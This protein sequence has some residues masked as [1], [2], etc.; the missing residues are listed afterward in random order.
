VMR[1]SFVD[2]ALER[3]PCPVIF[4]A[5]YRGHRSCDRIKKDCDADG[6]TFRRAVQPRS[7]SSSSSSSTSSWC[8]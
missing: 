4:G 5:G 8:A 3:G 1:A 2:I 6:R 7:S